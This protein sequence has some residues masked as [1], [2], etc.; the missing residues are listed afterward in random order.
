MSRIRGK[1]TSPE[2]KVR[3]LLHRAGYR[4]RLHDRNLP[5]IPDII[6]RKYGT[7]IFVHGCF[8]HR[9]AGCK[10]AY[11]PKSRVDFWK[12]KFK[13]NVDRDRKVLR[14]LKSEGWKVIVIWECELRDPESLLAR[15]QNLLQNE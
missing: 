8:W 3:S 11:N 7:V 15:L 5:G 6:L 4:F 14:E 9:H 12:K 2:R 13:S 10:Y 1:D